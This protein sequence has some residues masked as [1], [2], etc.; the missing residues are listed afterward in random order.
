MAAA[1]PAEASSRS[2]LKVD[3]ECGILLEAEKKVEGVRVKAVRDCDNGEKK[4][5]NKSMRQCIM[6]CGL[7]VPG[8]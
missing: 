1:I 8:G 4:E 3:P 2:H 6:I 5:E 7:L